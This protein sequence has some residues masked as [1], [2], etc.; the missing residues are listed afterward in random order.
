MKRTIRII[1]VLILVLGTICI[2][3]KKG[4]QRETVMDRV[5]QIEKELIVDIPQVPRWCDQ[6]DL[7]KSRVNIG[8]CELYVEEEGKGMP[9]V[10][11][12]GGPGGTHHNFHPYFSR[13]KKFARIIYY[14]QRGCGL[15]D[16]NPGKG[17]SVAQA[18]DDLE[19]LRMALK[20]D[21]WVV[22][23]WSYGGF[24]GQLYIIKYPE[25]V[26]GLILLTAKPG[27]PGKL[28]RTR[29]YEYISKEEM[30]KMREIS[31]GIYKIAKEKK[32][33][34]EQTT[35]LIVYN[36]H[37]NGDWKRQSHYKPSKEEL[38]QSALYGWKHDTNFNATM[39]GDMNKYN[40]DGAFESCPI[41]TLILD[42][43]W[44]L[45]WNT[46]KPEKL[47]KNHPGSQFVI[48]E[49]SGHSP[50]QDETKRFFKVLGKFI[51]N[52]PE[53]SDPDISAWKEYI[54]KWKKEQEDPYLVGEMS[55]EERI[56]IQE[57][58]RKR[59]QFRKGVRHEDR[60]TPLTAFL[61]YLSWLHFRDK[62][63]LDKMT[64]GYEWPEERIASAGREMDQIDVLRA[65]PP[66]ERPEEAQIWPVYIKDISTNEH[67]DTH[68]F[69]FWEGK[70]VRWGNMGG[71]YDWRPDEAKLKKFF[72]ETFKKK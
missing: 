1:S 48:F 52:L 24:L 63:A 27:L 67:D 31:L 61:T 60:S 42:S 14:D 21:K 65:P 25:S 43:K 47:Q 50:F 15:S 59:A 40:L 70:W 71:P 32:L 28:E 68:L 19:N 23:G 39:S 22:L 18:V 26:T 37:I 45:T 12:H 35:E 51:K 46:D 58:R 54:E 3:C 11:L 10:L 6:L 4:E 62:A 8:D 34:R 33:T 49:K 38:A 53:V 72:L 44:D 56:A 9:I 55:E 16:Y 41:P 2:S 30:A 69:F 5:V 13:A 7:K 29:Q 57:F 20:I 36:R 64:P 66:P 17:Y